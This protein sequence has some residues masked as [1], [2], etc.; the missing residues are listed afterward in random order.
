MVL[1][2]NGAWNCSLHFG[3]SFTSKSLKAGKDF[4]LRDSVPFSKVPDYLSR[5]ALSIGKAGGK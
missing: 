5:M 3:H 4:R 2:I 1:N